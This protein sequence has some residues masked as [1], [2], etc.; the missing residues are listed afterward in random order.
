MGHPCR[1]LCQHGRSINLDERQHLSG[2]PD[3]LARTVDGKQ[4][5]RKI[6]PYLLKR[7]KNVRRVGVLPKGSAE[8]MARLSYH[9]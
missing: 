3:I 2:T 7:N 1:H 6:P 4:Q 5:A 8:R 9:F